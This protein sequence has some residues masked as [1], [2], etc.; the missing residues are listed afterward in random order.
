MTEKEYEEL[1][2]NVQTFSSSEIIEN[3]VETPQVVIQPTTTAP[4]EIKDN[5]LVDSIMQNQTAI[6]IAKSSFSNLKN[7]KDIAKRMH[8]IVK[9]KTNKDLDTADLA[10]KDQDVS[11]KVKRQEQ[12]NKLYKLQEEKKFLQRESRHK[13]NMQKNNQR[14]EK[15]A[16]LLL[17]HCRKKVKDENGKYK[18]QLDKEGNPLI[19]MP[20]GFVLFWLIFFDSIVQF[21]NQTGQIISETNKIV[22]KVFWIIL[23]CIVLFVPPI[24]NWLF[25]LIGL[26]LG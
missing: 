22:F 26:N 23:I 19:N 1:K 24:R 11:N 5:K 21:L 13:L 8:K 15:Y 2:E 4:V 12:K 16:D 18:F 17:R 9:D 6:D 25:G 20:N 7:Q 3:T 14:K 10:V